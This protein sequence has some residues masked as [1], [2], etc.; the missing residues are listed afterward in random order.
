MKTTLVYLIITV[1][2]LSAYFLI[3]LSF[4]LLFSSC[5]SDEVAPLPFSETAPL[6]NSES[7]TFFQPIILPPQ[8]TRTDYSGATKWQLSFYDPYH[9][10]TDKPVDLYPSYFSTVDGSCRTRI[11]LNSSAELTSQVDLSL[12]F[13]RLYSPNVSHNSLTYPEAARATQ[14]KPANL[15]WWQLTTMTASN[16]AQ[17][18]KE[19]ENSPFA[20]APFQPCNYDMEGDESAYYQ[21][22]DN[23]L[24]KTDRIPARYGAIYIKERPSLVRD[25]KQ[26]VIE[27]I[28]Q[29]DNTIIKNATSNNYETQDS[30][31]VLY[32]KLLAY[33]YATNASK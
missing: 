17:F 1:K 12:F 7:T 23:F 26:F 11:D 32:Q 20:S 14:I 22:G 21:K 19:F 3:A 8:V 30:V 18:T 4:A 5:E 27:V 9:H 24:F 15:T 13:S 28:V 16:P 31:Q 2:T 29:N 33:I 10:R 6:P 25:T